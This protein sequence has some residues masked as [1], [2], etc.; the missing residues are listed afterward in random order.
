MM[1]DT[2]GNVGTGAVLDG[3]KVSGKIIQY[4]VAVSAFWALIYTVC[5]TCIIEFLFYI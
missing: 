1:Q 4:C 5:I 3:V 2:N